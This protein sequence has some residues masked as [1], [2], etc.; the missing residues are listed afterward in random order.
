MK[1]KICK[2][3]VGISIGILSLYGQVY[4]Y[5]DFNGTTIDTTKWKIIN[6]GGSY[7]M[8]GGVLTMYNGSSYGQYFQILSKDSILPPAKIKFRIKTTLDN[9]CY[10]YMPWGGFNDMQ[11]R[12]EQ[13]IIYPGG[14]VNIYHYGIISQWRTDSIIWRNDSIKYY[15]ENNLV[16]VHTGSFP[17][18]R[19]ASFAI[20]CDQ[21]Y[22]C[23]IWAL[24]LDWVEMMGASSAQ[25]KPLIVLP[26]IKEIPSFF[27]DFIL[28]KFSKP[29]AFP[30]KVSLYNLNGREIIEKCFNPPLISA[31]I[32]K[33]KELP[34][35]IY[36]LKISS[37]E[38]K[39][40][41]FKVIKN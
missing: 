3:I 37:K 2:I 13:Y 26:E 40:K 20:N 36:F 22:G 34:K 23:Y 30:F 31:K 18:T 17:G 25:E 5:D 9:N 8:G 35:G 27:E 6:N 32:E 38:E 15:V 14:Y 39:I 7:V 29:V 28:I 24:D 21:L 4:L 1:G 33:L 16:Y 12:Y 10:N 41:Q 19:K 11:F